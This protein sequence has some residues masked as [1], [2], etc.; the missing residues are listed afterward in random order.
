MNSYDIDSLRLLTRQRHEQRLREADAER[1]VR[2]LRAIRRR[3]RLRW[4][5]L[6]LGARHRLRPLRL[7]S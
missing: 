6:P 3:R 1:L 4:I 5:R 7:E 2:R